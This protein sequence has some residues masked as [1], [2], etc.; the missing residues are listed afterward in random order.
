[1]SLINLTING[2]AVAVEEGTN[3]LEA[4]KKVNIK[5]PNLCYLHID[6]IGFDNSC[7]SCRVCLVNA[8][9]RLVPS[10]ATLAKEGMKVQTNTPEIIEFRKGVVELLLSDH[11]QDCY[12]CT[13][14]GSC[15]LQDIAVQLGIKK[16]RFEG[17]RLEKSK[18]YS[19][20]SIMR[21]NDKCILCRRCETMCN[22]VQKVGVLSGVNRGF[23]TEIGTFFETDLAKTE[24]T[25][26]GQCINVCP[27]GALLEKDN[28][29]EAWGLLAQKEKPVMVQ[30]APA[31]RVGISEEFGL[32]PGT[33]STGKVVAA[34]KA[35]GFDYVFDTNF[36][37][38]L[39]IMEEANEFVQRLT[40]GGDLPIM[41]SCC[42]AWVNFCETQ[43]PDLLKYL[44]TC[45]SPQSMF[46]P[47]ARYYFADKVLGK[48]ADEVIVMSIMPCIAKKYEVAR[49][50]L[51]KDGIIDTDLSLTVRELARMIKEAGIDLATIEEAEF[52]SPLGYSTGAADI[53][54]V[55]G[56]V[57]EAALRTA[58]TDVT[59]EEL[60]D[61]A[62]EFKSV[63]GF[64]GIKEATVNVGGTDVNVV[65]ASSLGCARKLMD[66]LRADL[67]AGKTPKYHIIEIMACPGGCV[68]G[69]GQPFHGG[70]YEKVKARGA[71][72]YAI[73]ANKPKRKS[74]QNQD[75][76]KLYAE[77]L[78]ERGGHNAH[79]YLHTHYFDRSNPYAKEDPK[80]AALTTE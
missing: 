79:T 16:I 15:G 19:S 57:L 76:K 47:V 1:M 27:T 69:G 63:R 55:T 46:S 48:K 45:R 3:I 43:Y 32:K 34:L 30:I 44:S 73:D 23:S 50:E 17:E 26:C 28:T 2:K 80:E 39:T 35:L 54:G 65:A 20:F 31:V 11:P 37:A 71:G 24:C 10:C 49:E 74:H 21:D 4:A 22:Q 38:D 58:Y 60:P 14:C 61:D 41:T 9:G 75:I 68:A 52:D 33:I 13:K 36:A 25:F 78:G 40:K 42:P 66:E 7:A 56:G 5:I 67:A 29:D 72:L 51:G 18:D 53:F 64:E 8:D 77:F 62:I 59:K 70:D 6:D 12:T